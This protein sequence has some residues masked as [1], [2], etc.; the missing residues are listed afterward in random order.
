MVNKVKIAK[1]VCQQK[2]FEGWFSPE[3]KIYNRLLNL[4]VP[5]YVEAYLSWSGVDSWCLVMLV[6][7]KSNARNS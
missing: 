1:N 2:V 7:Q 4:I 5:I 6:L 3:F